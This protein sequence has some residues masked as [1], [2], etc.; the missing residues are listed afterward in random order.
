M[1]A[2]TS[3]INAMYDDSSANLNLYPKSGSI[4][5]KY[6]ISFVLDFPN[7]KSNIVM[8]YINLTMQAGENKQNRQ[9]IDSKIAKKYKRPLVKETRGLDISSVSGYLYFLYSKI[10][11]RTG[12]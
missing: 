8:L 1:N 6:K 7:T 2:N 11:E 5:S 12:F 10:I 9:I 4:F 3:K